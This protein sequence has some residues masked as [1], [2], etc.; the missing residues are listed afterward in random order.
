MRTMYTIKVK[1]PETGSW[2]RIPF[3]WTQEQGLVGKIL[4]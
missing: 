2:E 3:G 4:Y 1:T